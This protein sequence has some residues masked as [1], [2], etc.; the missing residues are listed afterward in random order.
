MTTDEQATEQP[1]VPSGGRHR[2]AKP[3]KA[4]RA[5]KAPKAAKSPKAPKAE[6]VSKGVA[7]EAAT[8]APQ[9]VDLT[10]ASVL[11]LP[12]P[13]RSRLPV[14]AIP[15]VL[16][17]AIA[18]ALAAFLVHR[19]TTRVKALTKAR[20]DAVAAANHAVKD[21]LSY[22][23]R[24]ISTDIATAKKDITGQLLTDYSA[25]A[26]KLLPQ[27]PS[28]KAIV[29]ATVSGQ[30]VVRAQSDRVTMLMY[31]DQESIRQLPGEKSLSTR[32][33]PLRIQLTM[34][35]VHGRWLASELQPV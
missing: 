4:P 10:K 8:T 27:A 2:A 23:Y 5:P 20:A 14:F 13:R 26:T 7:P 12:A 21:V 18:C 35:K 28:V 11:E 19:D 30:A 9:V 6:K 3:G 31:V 25:S 15:I 32:I 34:T 1:N 24:K 33:D 17:L 16:V 29:T 22:D